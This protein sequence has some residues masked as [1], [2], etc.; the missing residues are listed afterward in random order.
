MSRLEH[1]T[2]DASAAEIEE[3]IRDS[4]AAEL[5]VAD[6]APKEPGVPADQ[7][8]S[9]ESLQAMAAA[10]GAHITEA[11]SEH[12]PSQR[13]GKKAKPRKIGRVADS[14][15]ATQP[16]KAVRPIDAR[17]PL[18]FDQ[19]FDAVDR[20]SAELAAGTVR[21]G[22]F[23]EL[24]EPGTAD[25]K[26]WGRI[27]QQDGK[28]GSRQI[29]EK[30][31]RRHAEHMREG[32][33][34]LYRRDR[35]IYRSKTKRVDLLIPIEP[36]PSQLPEQA[37]AAFQAERAQ[38]LSERLRHDLQ[39]SQNALRQEGA[40]HVTFHQ[41]TGPKGTQY[42]R[43]VLD[44]DGVRCQIIL[45]REDE[46][47]MRSGVAEPG[48]RYYYAALDTFE[49]PHRQ[50]RRRFV[51]IREAKRPEEIHLQKQ[52][53]RNHRN[54]RQ[55]ESTEQPFLQTETAKAKKSRGKTPGQLKRAAEAAEKRRNLPHRSK[56]NPSRKR[57]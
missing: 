20:L 9:L 46:A 49:I 5:K 27:Y 54:R 3:L 28:Q 24:T 2:P 21:V 35:T 42:S 31:H 16:R 18:T 44:H 48:R 36:L 53:P 10:M 26:F 19:Y 41:E 40:P 43:T 17:E 34:V 13:N 45:T 23:R 29:I 4:L 14:P 32:A 30:V 6:V 37:I 22:V 57:S 1:A 38:E 11:S 12:A 50:M 33:P 52:P 55:R 7:L 25:Q 8:V 15:A 47:L 39:R 51:T 56:D